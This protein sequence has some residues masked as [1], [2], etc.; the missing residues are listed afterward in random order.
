MTN[1]DLY[2]YFLEQWITLRGYRHLKKERYYGITQVGIVLGTL[3][4]HSRTITDAQ[5]HL[6]H[7]RLR[8]LRIIIPLKIKTYYTPPSG[9]LFKNIDYLTIEMDSS[10]L[11]FWKDM[12]DLCKEKLVI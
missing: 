7:S 11:T 4:V 1:I 3:N 2:N 5:Y 8:H 12:V 6:F 10:M 9:P